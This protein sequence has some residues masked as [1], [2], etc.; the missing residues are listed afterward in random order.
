[1]QRQHGAARQ[2]GAG[3]MEE[4][5]RLVESALFPGAESPA[6]APAASGLPDFEVGHNSR[7]TVKD[8]WQLGP[9]PSSIGALVMPASIF[10]C[11]DLLRATR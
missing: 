6:Q 8:R 2:S 5:V 4:L 11:S 1:M 7:R 10:N 3:I 9:Y